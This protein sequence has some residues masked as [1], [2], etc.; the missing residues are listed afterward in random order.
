[1]CVG[2]VVTVDGE[3]LQNVQTRV[4]K[5]HRI[6]VELYPLLKNKDALMKAKIHIVNSNVKS[7]LLCGCETWEVTTQITNKLQ[8]LLTDVCEVW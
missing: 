6:F 4:T 8:S 2:N 1:V 3:A 7:I 5:A